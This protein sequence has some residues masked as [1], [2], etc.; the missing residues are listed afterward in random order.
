MLHVQPAGQAPSGQM[1]EP[2]LWL[3]NVA[4]EQI[5]GYFGRDLLLQTAILVSIVRHVQSVLFSS[6]L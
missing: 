2:P 3:R 5:T 6:V 4:E 1:Q